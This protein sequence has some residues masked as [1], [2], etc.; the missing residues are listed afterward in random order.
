[1]TF[2]IPC[3]LWVIFVF[4]FA[5]MNSRFCRCVFVVSLLL[6]FAV[7]AQWDWE[8]KGEVSSID[9]SMP[10]YFYDTEQLKRN[11]LA[12]IQDLGHTNY[13]MDYANEISKIP[14]Q[15]AKDTGI[16]YG[17]T[18]WETALNSI[19]RDIAPYS[20]FNREYSVI[21]VNDPATNAFATEGGL[22]LVTVGM[23]ADVHSMDELRLNLGHEI[24]SN[25]RIRSIV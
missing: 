23:L 22:V 8:D 7:Q 18:D 15:L 6:P 25:F 2:R 19:V 13:Q 4:Y 21:I 24:E 11:V 14:K 3:C 9:T 20:S 12:D 10:S 5:A 16:V 17:W 1:M